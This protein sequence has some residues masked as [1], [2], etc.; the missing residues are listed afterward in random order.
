[1]TKV[2]GPDDEAAADEDDQEGQLRPRRQDFFEENR[3]E[4]HDEERRQLGNDGYIGQGHPA[5][6][7]ENA[8]HADTAEDA[9]QGQRR[10][11]PLRQMYVLDAH[12]P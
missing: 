2:P 8:D 12:E 1:M 7:I 10:Y 9:A 11:I 6:G 5:Q 3:R 4:E